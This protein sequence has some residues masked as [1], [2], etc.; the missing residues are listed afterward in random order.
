MSRWLQIRTVI[1]RA[2]AAALLVLISPFIAVLGLVVRLRDGAP[3]FITVPRV[4]RGGQVFGMWKIRSM[5][6]SQPDGRADGIG[7]SSTEDHRITPTGRW[8]RSY[9]LDELPQLVNV[10][11]GRMSLLGPRPEAPEFVDADDPLWHDVLA[12]P[13]GIAGPT[14][15]LVSAW[16]DRH[17]NDS[18]TGRQY[19]EVVLPV[20]L[21]IDRWYVTRSSP[22]LDILVL[23]SLARRLVG[24]SGVP[25][26]TERV[27]A[28]VPEAEQIPN[29]D[30]P[31]D[32]HL[33]PGL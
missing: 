13:P 9:Y 3:S 8:L 22:R 33:R 4:G 20:K 32:P 27:R 2:A 31:A 11:A 15:L 21:A 18:P 17:I 24:R 10:V 6:A 25:A 1:D 30:T 28:Q 12:A 23:G 5:T 29:H 19:V 16:E 14:Q 26:L 7:L